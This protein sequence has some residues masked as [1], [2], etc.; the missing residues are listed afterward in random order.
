MSTPEDVLAWVAELPA[1]V[2]LMYA[3]IA[4]EGELLDLSFSMAELFFIVDRV[5]E[6]GRLELSETF[7]TRTWWILA[8]RE[9]PPNSSHLADPIFAEFGRI[10]RRT[11]LEVLASV[12]A[13]RVASRQADEQKL[14]SSQRYDV[15]K[16]TWVARQVSS[17]PLDEQCPDCEGNHRVHRRGARAK[18]CPCCVTHK[19]SEPGFLD[20]SQ[21]DWWSLCPNCAFPSSQDTDDGE[22]SRSVAIA[23]DSLGSSAVVPAVGQDMDASAGTCGGEFVRA[24]SICAGR[25]RCR[26]R[27]TLPV[28]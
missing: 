5:Q 16:G 28:A 7:A 23:D 14:R 25:R 2:M 11:V 9:F 22:P 13:A 18:G 3:F 20:R 10:V 27:C 8:I 19:M 1:W 24:A 6:M 15:A 4:E 21:D 26:T 17:I 12:E